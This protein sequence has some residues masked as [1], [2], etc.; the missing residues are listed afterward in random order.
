MKDTDKLNDLARA[1]IERLVALGI[2][3]TPDEIVE[4]NGLGWGI[5]TPELRLALA[6]GVPVFLNGRAL[7][8]MT[9]C[10]E[11]W[12][13]REG[14]AMKGAMQDIAM[15]Y[16]M[17]H[18]Y[19]EEGALEVGGKA[20]H[21][22]VKAWAKTLR[23]TLNELREAVAQVLVQEEK[24]AVPQSVDEKNLTDGEFSIYLT[25]LAGESPEFWER[26][27]SVGYARATLAAVYMQNAAEGKP[28]SHDPKIMAERAMGLRIDQIMKAH[29]HG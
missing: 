9:L 16:A 8:P 28:S 10:A 22:A 7:W 6:R 3:P 21:K 26:R 14:L 2:Q 27:C 11:D 15:A 24:P 25:T 18:A 17:A 5:E 20:A 12:Y 13:R 19:D 23:A 4:L 1:E 29:G